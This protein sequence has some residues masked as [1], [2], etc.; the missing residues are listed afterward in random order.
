VRPP[1]ASDPRRLR[2]VELERRFK[3]MGGCP[4]RL[5][6]GSLDVPRD[7]PADMLREWLNVKAELD[8]SPDPAAPGEP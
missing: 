4:R 7:L 5:A 6:D 1:R 2:L 3:G 8:A